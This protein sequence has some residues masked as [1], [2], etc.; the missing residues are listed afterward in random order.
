MFKLIDYL[1][2]S[3]VPVLKFDVQFFCET[4]SCILIGKPGLDENCCQ[5]RGEW[6]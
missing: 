3:T 1:K 5:E 4:V 6:A 2:S